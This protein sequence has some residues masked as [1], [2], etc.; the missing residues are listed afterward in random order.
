MPDCPYCGNPMPIDR[1]K[2]CGELECRRAIRSGHTAR[3]RGRRE[4]TLA[5]TLPALERRFLGALLTHT[6][7]VRTW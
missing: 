2:S 1:T 6:F 3:P 4:A 5:E 7:N